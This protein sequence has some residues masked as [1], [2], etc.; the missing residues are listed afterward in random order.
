M[1]PLGLDWD[2]CLANW[3]DAARIVWPKRKLELVVG[4][5][6]DVSTFLQAWSGNGEV[7][8]LEQQTA[9]ANA[10]N[11]DRSVESGLIVLEPGS[12]V[13]TL[14]YFELFSH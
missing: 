1:D 10:V 6:D 12:S 14:H 8:A 3:N 11:L 2:H 4:A 13:E 7:W 9:P 5:S